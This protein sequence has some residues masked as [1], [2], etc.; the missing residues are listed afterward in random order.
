MGCR[1]LG[2]ND[3][4]CFYDSCSDVAFGPVT[5]KIDL[6]GFRNWLGKDPRSV[7]DINDKWDEYVE[8]FDE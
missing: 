5:N 7:E 4:C 3:M 6:E 8:S 1:I 2:S